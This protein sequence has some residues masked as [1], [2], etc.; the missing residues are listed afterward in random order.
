MVAIYAILLFVLMIFPHELGHFAVAKWVGVQVNEFALGMGPTIWK[1]EKGETIYSLRLVPIGGFCAMEGENDESDNPRAFNNK[2]APAKIAVLL[3]GAM[4]NVITA[5]LILVILSFCVGSASTTIAD[6][7]KDSPAEIAGIKAEDKI[8]SVNGSMVES[9]GQ[10]VK[11]IKSSRG[12]LI[13]VVDRQGKKISFNVQPHNQNGEKVIGIQS[14]L[15][16]SPKTA[17]SNGTIAT[18][19][20]GKAMLV[21]FKGLI[22]GGVSM[23]DVAGPVG[24]VSMVGQTSKLGIQYVAGLV[25]L[26]SLNLAIINL[27]PLPALDGGRI[28][29]VIIRKITGKMISDKTEGI[30]HMIGMALLLMLAILVTIN[31]VGKLI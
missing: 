16:R 4:M 19:E 8:I 27:L 21:G 7:N 31:D 24:M 12:D 29:F 9:W 11:K 23:K 2:S 18:Y 15:V 5:W 10:S 28:I 6:V 14:K 22:T 13:L 20:M 3:A 25:A 17:I 1:K 30:V 26:V